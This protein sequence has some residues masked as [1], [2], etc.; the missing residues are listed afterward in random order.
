MTR[1]KNDVDFD[2]WAEDAEERIQRIVA[3]GG[4]PLAKLRALIEEGMSSPA[5]PWEG[6]DTI[7]RLVHR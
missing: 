5:A 1:E 6:A 7:K 2:P 3:G 4:Q